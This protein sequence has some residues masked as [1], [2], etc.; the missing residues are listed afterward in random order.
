MKST[1]PT[2][3]DGPPTENRPRLTV[4]TPVALSESTKLDPVTDQTEPILTSPVM[5]TEEPIRDGPC[6]LNS[7]A[8]VILPPI[9]NLLRAI[10]L[11]SVV[12]FDP[13]PRLF[14]T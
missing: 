8:P 3:T 6:M 1:E 14:R 13:T 12:M 7:E 2:N 10:I 5:E 11:S 9:Y 4:I